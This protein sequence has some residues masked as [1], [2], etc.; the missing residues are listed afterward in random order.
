VDATMDEIGQMVHGLHLSRD[1]LRPNLAQIALRMSFIRLLPLT[2]R[3]QR[4]RGYRHPHR[5]VR[6]STELQ[7]RRG[8]AAQPSYR[9]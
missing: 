5:W 6:R 2:Y 3:D 7:S 9:K 8:G 4:G 1:R